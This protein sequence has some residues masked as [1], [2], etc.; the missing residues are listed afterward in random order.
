[1]AMGLDVFQVVGYQNSGKTTLISELIHRCRQNNL[2]V[3]SLKHHGHE[4]QH[5][6]GLEKDT[7]HHQASGSLLTG[8]VTDRELQL[9]LPRGDTSWSLDKVIQIYQQHFNFELIVVEGYKQAPYPK[10]V[11]LRDNSEASLLDH[12]KNVVCVITWGDPD[13]LRDAWYFPVFHIHEK[14]DYLNVLIDR[15]GEFRNV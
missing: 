15:I 11:L 8:L 5:R 14:E 9:T 7:D 2:Q 13:E 10:V 4:E 6:N 1:M 12:L 3:A